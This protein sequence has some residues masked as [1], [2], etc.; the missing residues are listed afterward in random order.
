M[1]SAM[2]A[3]LYSPQV[4]LIVQQAPSSRDAS[5]FE[6]LFDRKVSLLV[7]RDARSR[8]HLDLYRL[9]ESLTGL[10]E[11]P[12]GARHRTINFSGCA[13]F[14]TLPILSHSQWTQARE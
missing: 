14:G 10:R 4:Q 1:S 9:L 7:D 2:C 12:V 6:R 8:H 11:L 5:E 13:R 3:I